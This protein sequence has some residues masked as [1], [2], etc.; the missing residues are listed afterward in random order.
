MAL[1]ARAAPCVRPLRFLMVCGLSLIVLLLAAGV[2][3]QVQPAEAGSG[4]SLG[5]WQPDPTTGLVSLKQYEADAGKHAAIVELWRDWAT[6]AGSL[7]PAWL[8]AIAAHGSVPLITWDPINW[9]GADQSAY[10]LDAILAGGQD[11]YIRGWAQQL[12][13]YGKPVMLRTMEQMNGSWN[14]NWSGD[15]AKF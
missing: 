1:P 8:S 4:L 15:P 6:D 12:T 14:A 10:T 11:G 7:T 9:S 3:R 5:V 2:G 13:A